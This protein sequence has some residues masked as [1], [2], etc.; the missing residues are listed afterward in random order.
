MFSAATSPFSS[1]GLRIR[2]CHTVYSSQG[3]ARRKW[4]NEKAS[5]IEFWIGVPVT[6]H[7]RSACSAKTARADWVARPLTSCASSSTTRRQR[8]ANGGEVPPAAQSLA[9]T[10]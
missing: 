9:S 8:S 3:D 1:S 6:A 2:L 7:R 5:S 4:I 10:P